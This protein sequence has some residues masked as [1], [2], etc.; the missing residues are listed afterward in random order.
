MPKRRYWWAGLLVW[1]VDPPV[2]AP[3]NIHAGHAYGYNQP[4]YNAVSFACV[5][6]AA[7]WPSLRFSTSVLSAAVGFLSSAV[8][9]VYLFIFY[10]AYGCSTFGGHSC[11]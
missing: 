2:A 9:I 7:A 6:C 8:A 1:I 11:I 10:L 3:A 5:A 4:F